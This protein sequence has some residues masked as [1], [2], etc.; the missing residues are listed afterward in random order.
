LSLRGRTTG[1][2]H[3]LGFLRPIQLAELPVGGALT[4]QRYLQA[5]RHV[6]LPRPVDRRDTDVQRLGTLLVAPGRPLGIGIGF[7]QNVGPRPLG[8][9]YCALVDQPLQ[10]LPFRG[11]ET[12]DVLDVAYH[13]CSPFLGVLRKESRTH[14]NSAGVDH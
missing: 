14:V 6:R 3:Q 4:L 2:S 5:L 13:D 1:E 10:C 9:R 8:R 11:A 7:E 12:N